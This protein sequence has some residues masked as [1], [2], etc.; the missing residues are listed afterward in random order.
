MI[1]TDTYLTIIAAFTIGFILGLI[2]LK[3][4]LAVNK[5]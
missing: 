3:V 2:V 4:L 1:G 5:K